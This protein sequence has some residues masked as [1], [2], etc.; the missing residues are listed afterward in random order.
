MQNVKNRMQRENASLVAVTEPGRGQAARSA[1]WQRERKRESEADRRWLGTGSMEERD[2]ISGIRGRPLQT[3]VGE[4]VR[5]L[6]GHWPVPSAAAPERCPLA[7]LSTGLGEQRQLRQR[8][9]EAASD[10]VFSPRLARRDKLPTLATCRTRDVHGQSLSV[11]RSRGEWTWRCLA[12]ASFSR[13]QD[14]P[15]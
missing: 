2:D 15:R 10:F 12:T 7:T 11:S 13:C 4:R 6:S 3:L 8:C 5:A 14:T 9:S 1:R